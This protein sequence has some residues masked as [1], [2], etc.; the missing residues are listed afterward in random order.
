MKNAVLFT[1]TVVI[2]N[3]LYSQEVIS[4]AGGSA[5][6]QSIIVSYTIGE[7][8]VETFNSDDFI[9]TQG[10][11][12]PIITITAIET[13]QCPGFSIQIFPNPTSTTLDVLVESESDEPL[14]YSFFDASGKILFEKENQN[15]HVSFDV[16]HLPHGTYV[17]K[18]VYKGKYVSTFKVIK[19]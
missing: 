11:N 14:M 4:N 19:Q 15:K 6:N 7:P 18:V 16:K 8:I 13:P 2:S 12:Q 10:F 17:L 3:L 1:L 9:V 5:E